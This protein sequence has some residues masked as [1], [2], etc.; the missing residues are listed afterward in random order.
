[1]RMMQEQ[2]NECSPEEEDRF[3]NADCERRFQHRARLV[4]IQRE[5]VVCAF[6]VRPEWAQGDPD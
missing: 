5:R 2:R 3:H 4:N 1:M 6:A